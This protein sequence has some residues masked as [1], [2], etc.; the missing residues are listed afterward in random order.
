MVE[1]LSA[2]DY[3]GPDPEGSPR[4]N[5]QQL[6]KGIKGSHENNAFLAPLISLS[7][8]ID[9]EIPV[10]ASHEDIGPLGGS[11]SVHHCEHPHRTTDGHTRGFA[12]IG[13]FP[14]TYG[15][16]IRIVRRRSNH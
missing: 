13:P 15:L 4:T 14:N 3:L 1:F 12:L 6:G 7:P 10:A 2:K 8:P 16:L 5:R 9:P 11:G